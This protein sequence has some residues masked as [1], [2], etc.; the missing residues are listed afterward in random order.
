MPLIYLIFAASGAAGLIYQVLWTRWLGLVF[1]NTTLSVSIV[2]GCFMLGLALGG[3]LAGRLLAKVAQ[4][5]AVYAYLE[6]GIAAFALIFPWLAGGCDAAYLALVDADSAPAWSLTVR[7]ALSALVLLVPTTLM[8]ATLPLLTD[9]LQRT[10]A[11]RT[12]APGALY[13]ANALGAGLGA[14]LGSFVL[15]EALGVRGATLSAAA[16]N[17]I[18]GYGALRL[19]RGAA[20]AAPP[21]RPPALE[22][23]ALVALGVLAAS[24]AAALACEVLWTRALEGLLGNSSYAFATLLFVYL[25]GIS[26]GSG[27]TSRWVKRLKSPPLWLIGTQL[28]LACWTALG[29]N[30]FHA[31]AASLHDR[32]EAAVSTGTL[33][34]V[35]LRSAAILLPLALLSGAAFTLATRILEPR[36]SDAGGACAARAYT[37]NTLGAVA[38]SLCA[39]F[40]I[41]PRLDFLEAIDLLA[42]LY[43]AIAAA[44]ALGLFL[45]RGFP[46]R[47]LAGVALAAGLLVLGTA[48]RSLGRSAFIEGIRGASPEIEVL[49]HKPGLQG[50]ATIVRRRGQGPQD[51]A[52][53]INTIGMT[54]PGAI[55]KMMA[56]IPLLLHPDPKSAL[57]IGFGLGTTFRSALS[58]GVKATA[59][60]LVGEVF[61]TLELTFPDGKAVRADPRGRL[62]VN[63]GRNFLKL[64][65]ER[66]DVIIVDPPPPIDAAGVN[67]LYS[68]EFLRLV[69]GRLNDGGIV[70]HGIP[71]P[72]HRSGVND[73][74]TFGMLL[75]TFAEVFPYTYTVPCR[76]RIGI[77]M[78]GSLHPLE[79]SPQTLLR[80]LARGSARRDAEEWGGTPEVYLGS[81]ATPDR[82]LLAG[83]DVLTDDRP[84][85]EFSLLRSWREGWTRQLPPVWW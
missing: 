61:E 82:S 20:R 51:S 83:L 36:A 43:A 58:H 11:G 59:V 3:W 4:P 76:P 31:L 63:D 72:G 19:P 78:I 84:A 35:E 55:T 40:L 67:N 62:V 66:F 74:A 1:G 7:A 26:L 77:H 10:R 44:G 73:W 22:S 47:A 42:A 13:A 30:L 25:I 33:L 79:T 38:G 14:V 18:G 71:F 23:L 8:G 75:R 68:L 15:I 27:L 54:Q 60:D 70:A 24:G 17:L 21:P 29:V 64:T 56:H 34:A 37:W 28:G 53:L 6:L 41:A 2:L 85:L 39:G 9:F 81:F 80:R 49:Y 32:G 12:W 48:R 5:A 45:V 50:V 16:L 57:I 65:P 69:K 52:L 46:K